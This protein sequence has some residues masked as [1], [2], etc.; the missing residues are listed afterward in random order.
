ML[1]PPQDK[2]PVLEGTF[3]VISWTLTCVYVCDQ[4]C[5]TL[6]DPLDYSLLGSSICE[7]FQARILE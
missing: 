4:S 7:I 5:L 1:F 2:Y 6:C 3:K